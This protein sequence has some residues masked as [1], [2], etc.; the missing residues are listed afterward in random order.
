MLGVAEVD[1]SGIVLDFRHC[2]AGPRFAGPSSGLAL[3]TQAKNDRRVGPT[4]K[5]NNAN[6]TC[7]QEFSNDG[8]VQTLEAAYAAKKGEPSYLSGHSHAR[9]GKSGFGIRL[10]AESQ[11]LM[12]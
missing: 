7:N 10:F 8:G 11:C 9:F 1:F 3:W 12:Q 6:S 5:R 4:P 2:Y